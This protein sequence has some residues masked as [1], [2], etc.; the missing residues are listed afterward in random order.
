MKR[1][2]A[3]LATGVLIAAA[4]VYAQNNNV[5]LT[6]EAN[7]FSQEK[8]QEVQENTKKQVEEVT[9]KVKQVGEQTKQVLGTAVQVNEKEDSAS[10]QQ[11][12]VE[13]GQYLYCKQVVTN[14]ET[15]EE[16]N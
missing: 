8:V 10:I 4:Y 16:V 5:S 1:I 2:F 12:A 3:L 11:R 15:K 13:Y 6:K 14:Y 9:N 7:S